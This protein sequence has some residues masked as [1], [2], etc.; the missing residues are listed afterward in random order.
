MLGKI[1]GAYG[2]RGW[3]KIKSYTDPPE[4]LLGYEQLLI[5]RTGHPPDRWTS[6]KLEDGRMT[7]K[8][9]L[10][11]V[12]G[13]DTP[14]EARARIGVELGVWRSQMPPPPPGQYYWADLEGLTAQSPSG[15]RLGTVDH[16]RSTPAGTMIVIRGE[17]E[18]WVPFVKERVV[19]VDL[20]S[21]R[22]VLDWSA[23]WS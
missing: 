8:G 17:R 22:I 9:V 2:V 23:E 18:L 13:I 19:Q 7:A 12:K 5:G 3:V 11:K 10:G 1:V 20:A 21:G 14:E 4:N 15:E 6:V 16:F